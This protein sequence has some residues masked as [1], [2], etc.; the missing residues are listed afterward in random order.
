MRG[1]MGVIADGFNIVVNVRVHMRPTLFVINA[2]LNDMEQMWDHAARREPLS[3]I[4]E[5]ESPWVGKAACEDFKPFFLRLVTPDTAINK[6]PIFWRDPRLPDERLG[7]HALASVQPT[8]GSP[9]KTV[10]CFVS[11]IDSPAV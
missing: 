4:V 8:V 1:Q 7:K 5:I 11:I 3:V 6:L 9:N 2:S 10:E